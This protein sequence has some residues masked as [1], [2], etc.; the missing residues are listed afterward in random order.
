LP[1]FPTTPN[2]YTIGC[3]G[4]E[5]GATTVRDG[6]PPPH[7]AIPNIQIMVPVTAHIFRRGG[8]I[9]TVYVLSLLLDP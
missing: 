5:L 1:R 9:L 4:I 7:A 3:P 2:L 8:P 6:L